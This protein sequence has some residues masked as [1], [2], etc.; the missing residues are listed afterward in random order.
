MP[1]V[2]TREPL[3]GWDPNSL[4]F[5]VSQ[6]DFVIL[7]LATSLFPAGIQIADWN[8]RLLLDP[9]EIVLTDSYFVGDAE[10]KLNLNIPAFFASGQVHLQALVLTNDPTYA[11]ASFTNVLSL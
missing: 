5:H 8:Y 2:E 9:N 6:G 4:R 11:P 10:G 3:N 1:M 7:G